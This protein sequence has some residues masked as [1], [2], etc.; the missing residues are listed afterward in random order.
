MTQNNISKLVH[1]ILVLI[2][3]PANALLVKLLTSAVQ[4][5]IAEQFQRIRVTPVALALYASEMNGK[6]LM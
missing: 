5:I 4:P 2:N 3:H 6:V 1:V